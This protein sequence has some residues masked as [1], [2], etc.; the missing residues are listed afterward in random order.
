[1]QFLDDGFFPAASL[2]VGVPPVESPGV[3]HLARSMHILR[4]KTGCRIRNFLLIIDAKR[5]LRSRLRFA[6]SQ[7]EPIILE[8][9]KRN[10]HGPVCAANANSY[11]MCSGCPQAKPNVPLFATFCPEGHAMAP[12]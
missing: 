7:L 12:L 6:G 9:V 4:L 8:L 3:N 11:L 10:S 5:I 2:P 1:M